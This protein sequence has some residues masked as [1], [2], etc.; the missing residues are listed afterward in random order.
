MTGYGVIMRYE[1]R[2][3]VCRMTKFKVAVAAV[4]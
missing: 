4:G 2:N 1:Y 3:I